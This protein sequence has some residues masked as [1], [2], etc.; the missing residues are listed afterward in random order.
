MVTVEPPSSVSAGSPFSLTVTDEYVL[1]GPV[2]SAF[3]GTVTLSLPTNNPGGSTTILG[4]NLNAT[5][6]N[7]AAAVFSGLTLN[8]VANGYTLNVSSNGVIS[9][10]STSFNVLTPPP[11]PPPAPTIIAETAVYT[12]KMKKGKKVGEPVF[13]GY[14]ITFST[15]MNDGTLANS[16]NYVI[17]TVVPVKKTKK[18]PATIKLTPVRFSVTGETSNTVTLKPAGTPFKTKAGQIP[19]TT[20]LESGCRGLP[21][22][23]RHAEHCQG[24]QED[25]AR[26]GNH[27]RDRWRCGGGF[28]GN[29]VAGPARCGAGSWRGWDGRVQVAAERVPV[30]DGVAAVLL[31]PRAPR[32]VD[33][34]DRAGGIGFDD[35]TV[36][37]ERG[38]RAG[39]LVHG[40]HQLAG[41]AWLDEPAPAIQPFPAG[42]RPAEDP[43]QLGPQPVEK[44]QCPPGRKTIA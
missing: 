8:N 32:L 40:R 16:A 30:A 27:H 11:P 42:D 21:C 24:R 10:T 6:S 19:V 34:G 33:D 23:H 3:D 1:G 5:A 26:L 22:V 17:D 36:A 7:G 20:G 31:A 35:A 13:A 37:E 9:A 2:D 41:R 29:G 38:D 12:Q 39:Q 14:M 44:R 25:H 15:A 4:G 18:K 28:P 43:G